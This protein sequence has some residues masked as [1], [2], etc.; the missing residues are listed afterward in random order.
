MR[1]LLPCVAL[2]G[3][4]LD[5]IGK[6]TALMWQVYLMVGPEPEM[7]R[8]FLLQ[9]RG[10]VTD[11][12]TERLIAGLPDFLGDWYALIAPKVRVRNG[13]HQHLFPLAPLVPGWKH[14]LDLVLRDT[15]ASLSWFPLWLKRLKA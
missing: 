9:V 2:K 13:V 11:A 14:M 3:H 1:R 6:A 15:L 8:S 4:M 7:V 10:I 12:G 5:R